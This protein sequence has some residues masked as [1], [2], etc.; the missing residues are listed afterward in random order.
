MEIADV[1]TVILVTQAIAGTVYA[2]WRLVKA[3]RKNRDD[4]NN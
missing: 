2:G 4:D 3:V 1:I